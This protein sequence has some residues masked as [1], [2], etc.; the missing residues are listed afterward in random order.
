M[1]TKCDVDPGP[2]KIMA[3]KD[4]TAV[5]TNGDDGL[6]STFTLLIGVLWSRRRTAL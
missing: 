4:L 2:G 1:V 6:I 3:V 5:L